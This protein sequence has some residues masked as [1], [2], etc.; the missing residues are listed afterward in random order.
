MSEAVELTRTFDC[1]GSSCEV[2]VGAGSRPDCALGALELAQRTLEAWHRRFSRFLPSSELSWLNA[3]PSQIVSVSPLMARLAQAIV[4]AGRTSGGLV[5]GTLLDQIE[6][7]GYV[8]DLRRPLPLAM[9]LGRAPA[10]RPAGT[11]PDAGW[12]HIEVDVRAG[13]VTRPPGVRLDSGG[14]AK[15][16]FADALAEMLASQ[17]SFAI[18]CAGDLAVGGRAAAARAVNVE[19][20]FDATTLHTFHLSGAAVATS[21]IGRR[22]WLDRDGRPAHHLLDPATGT[23]AFTG[24]VQATALAPS[25]LKAEIYAKAALLSGPRAAAAWLA[26]GGVIVFDDG[27]HRVIEPP[28]RTTCPP[29]RRAPSPS[30]RVAAASSY[31][32]GGRSSSGRTSVR[33]RVAAQTPARSIPI[34][35]AQHAGTST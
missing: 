8:R 26:H 28:R 16:L 21:G 3:N 34:R 5:D 31:A 35:A 9:A 12:R 25:A 17:P 29:L 14:L 23:P 1:F 10:R 6:A 11:P 30:R 19:S 4:L 20:P 7:A 22:S 24:I 15:G 27:S 33:V 32:L 2:L 18:N 13:T